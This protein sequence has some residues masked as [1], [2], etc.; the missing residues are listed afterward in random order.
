MSKQLISQVMEQICTGCGAKKVWEMVGAGQNLV[1]L[2]E[3][4]EWYVIGRKVIVD[5]EMVQLTAEACCLACVPAAAV[6]LALPNPQEEPADDI[7]L[8]SL[9]G[10]QI[11]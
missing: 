7:D 10:P 11:N 1:I 2:A 9:R 5:G 8:A 6:K 3:M 4:Q